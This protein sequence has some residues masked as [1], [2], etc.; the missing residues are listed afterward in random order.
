MLF[1]ESGGVSWYYHYFFVAA[2]LMII[3]HIGGS[4]RKEDELIFF[5][6]PYSFQAAFATI[7]MLLIIYLFAPT[8]TNPFIYFQF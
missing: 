2:L 5:K 4:M 6:S 3:G 8:N 7:T 1:I